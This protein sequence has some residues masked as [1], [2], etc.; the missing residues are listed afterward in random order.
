VKSADAL[1]WEA[2]EAIDALREGQYLEQLSQVAR[3]G[4]RALERIALEHR[5]RAAFGLWLNVLDGSLSMLSQLVRIE[6]CLEAAKEIAKTRWDWPGH[7]T[8]DKDGQ[9]E[10]ENLI[11][12]IRLGQSAP[13]NFSGKQ[14]SKANIA[15]LIA[16]NMY[17]TLHRIGACSS[18]VGMQPSWSAAYPAAK[19]LLPLTRKN[20]KAW[21]TAAK[22]LFED[23]FGVEFEN[24]PIFKQFQQEA[25]KRSKKQGKSPAVLQRQCIRKSIEQAFRSLAP[26][27]NKSGLNIPHHRS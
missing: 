1:Q 6:P 17:H 3:Y 26:K 12:L 27:R 20:Y 7:I 22:P 24:N 21:W 9:I 5:N 19:K 18:S 16:W 4:I 14:A 11:K 23:E 25:W 8:L 13:L 10:A 2:M 15:T